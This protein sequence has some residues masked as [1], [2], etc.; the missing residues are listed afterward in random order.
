MGSLNKVTLIG[1][2]GKD[3]IIRTIES[4]QTKVAS[5]SIATQQRDKDGQEKTDWHEI[6]AWRNLAELS[7]KYL[8]KGKQVYIE[9][10]ISYRTYQD[11]NGIDRYRTEVVADTIVLIGSRNSEK[12]N[13]NSFRIN[14]NGV[15]SNGGLLVESE[16]LPF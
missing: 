7:E 4:N 15:E 13:D 12:S 5:F 14:T 6:V 8:H 1:N 2:L 9:G 16:D 3:P 10:R 11:K